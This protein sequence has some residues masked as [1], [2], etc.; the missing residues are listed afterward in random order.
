MKKTCKWKSDGKTN[1][2]DTEC[3]R[4]VNQYPYDALDFT[5]EEYMGEGEA[6]EYCM[7]CGKSIEV[8]SKETE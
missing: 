7:F 3:G 4:M 1:C 2:A 5:S 6:W 8:K